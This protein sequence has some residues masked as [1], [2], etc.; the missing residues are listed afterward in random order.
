M[1]GQ[2]NL[3]VQ[4]NWIGQYGSEGHV[5]CAFDPGTPPTDR[6]SLPSYVSAINPGTAAF[7]RLN[8]NAT[9]PL[10]LMDPRAPVVL[11]RSTLFSYGDSWGNP[12]SIQDAV[13][14][15][16]GVT[17]FTYDANGNVLT[18]TNPNLHTWTHAYDQKDRLTTTTDPLGH[19]TSIRYDV[20]GN[21]AEVTDANVSDIFECVPHEPR[22]CGRL[23]WPASPASW[24]VGETRS[25]PPGHGIERG[26]H[27]QR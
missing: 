14:P 21:I 4:G 26:N 7:A 19:E 23:V 15:T 22:P 6:Q 11:Q 8:A 17:S 18:V 2:A 3:A 25:A 24:R 9:V 1:Q 27:Q 13:A 16:P 20:T 10:N 5:L 12:T